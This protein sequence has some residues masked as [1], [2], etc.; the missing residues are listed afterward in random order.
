[1][2]ILSL[3][4]LETCLQFLIIVIINEII[5]ELF[6][7]FV[8][9]QKDSG[10]AS[11]NKLHYY[12][13]FYRC[14]KGIEE[15]NK[16]VKEIV[17][18][19]SD[20]VQSCNIATNVHMLAYISDIFVRHLNTILNNEDRRLTIAIKREFGLRIQERLKNFYSI[21]P[22]MDLKKAIKSSLTDFIRLKQVSQE[23]NAISKT[24]ETHITAT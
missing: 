21:K 1:M 9:K 24:P 7:P 2:G 6:E 19:G 17:G 5:E 23:Y 14:S 10:T 11:Y 15:I 22:V 4:N 12:S 18:E 8:Q 20:N 3:K 16:H 13:I